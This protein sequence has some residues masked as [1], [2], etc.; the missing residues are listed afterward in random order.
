MTEP[1]RF[2]IPGVPAP[3]QRPRRGKGGHFYTPGKT[4]AYEDAVKGHALAGMRRCGWQRT[5][6]GSY[7]LTVRA[8]LPDRRR[9]DGDNI[10]K[11]IADGLNGLV[12]EDDTQIAE[13]HLYK[14]LD[15]AQPRVEVEL[16]R[17]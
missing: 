6:G 2:T 17:L 4:Q 10:G 13:W 5:P 12:I 8:F 3:K 11:V 1:L 7:A 14:A 16:R 9:R 15:P